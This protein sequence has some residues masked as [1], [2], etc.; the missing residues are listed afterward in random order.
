MQKRRRQINSNPEVGL[1]IA[2][3]KV[4]KLFLDRISLA[5]NKA[6]NGKSLIDDV[7]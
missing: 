5:A 1:P 4:E 2:E 7:G 3:T 6:R